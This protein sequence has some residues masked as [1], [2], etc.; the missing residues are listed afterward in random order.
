MAKK[1]MSDFVF[2]LL[3][4]LRII[5]P[6]IIAIT[7]HPLLSILLIEY[8]V[9]GLLSPQHVATYSSYHLPLTKKIL[10]YNS[11]DKPLDLWGQMWTMYPV[12]FASSRYYYVFENYRSLVTI[13]FLYRL[14]G[15]IWYWIVSFLKKDLLNKK[16][17]IKF[18][19]VYLLVY[20]VVAMMSVLALQNVSV[21]YILLPVLVL[22]AI[23]KEHQIH[24][25]TSTWN[26]LFSNLEQF[27]LGKKSST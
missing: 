14:V 15:Y 13:F 3:I 8:I 16:I 22:I 17:F 10:G 9:D 2:Y 24:Q 21:I 4:S 11:Y 19:N 7:C 27:A 25:P 18:P 1:R 26:T 23:I 5:L 20:I 12:W 6:P